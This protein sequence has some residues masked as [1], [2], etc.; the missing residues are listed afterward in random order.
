VNATTEDSDARTRWFSW[1]T[2]LAALTGLSLLTMAQLLLA[3]RNR[4][5]DLSVREALLSGIVTWHQWVLYAPL[6]F[7]ICRRY[8]FEPARWQQSILVHLPVSI[9]FGFAW[10]TVRW[11]CSF[12]PWIDEY[13]LWYW[14]IFIGHFPLWFLAYWVLVSVHQAWHNYHRFRERELRASQLEAKLAQAQLEVLK[15]QLHPHFLFNTLHAISTLIHRDADAADEMVAQ[16]SDLLRMTLANIGIQEVTLQ[17]ELE[18]LHR[19]L[20]IQKMRFQDRL[21]VIIDVPVETLDLQVPNQVLQPIVENAVR[22]GVDARS[23]QGRIEVRARTTEHMLVLTVRDDGP[24]LHPPSPPQGGLRERRGIGL[25][26]TRARLRELYGPAATL[27]LEN[28][29]AGGTLVTLSSPLRRTGMPA[30]RERATSA[31]EPAAKP[32]AALPSLA[33]RWVAPAAN[34]E[35]KPHDPHSHR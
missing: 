31:E 5:M 33:S 28:H 17:Q 11:V 12:W 2:F 32:A 1:W 13:P 29:P 18:F 6:I 27:S 34:M 35:L 23:G 25:A 10:T 7:W 3:Y 20:D 26:N 14:R 22:H 16:L 24:G 9:G 15:M 30:V 4:G 21:T 19:Y 8:P